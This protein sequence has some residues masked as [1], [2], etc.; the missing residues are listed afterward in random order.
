MNYYKSYLP[1]DVD[2]SAKISG[3]KNNDLIIQKKCKIKV[4]FLYSGAANYSRLYYY[5]YPTGTIPSVSYVNNFINN[6]TD[7]NIYDAKKRYQVFFIDGGQWSNDEWFGIQSDC[8]IPSLDSRYPVIYKGYQAL[9]NYVSRPMPFRNNLYFYGENGNGTADIEIPAGYSI[10]FALKTFYSYN[11]INVADKAPIVYTTTSL[12]GGSASPVANTQV[13]RFLSTTGDKAL[14]MG[15]EDIVK[16]MR[17]TSSGDVYE[18]SNFNNTDACFDADWDFND[19]IIA[20]A[21][22]PDDGIYTPDDNPIPTDPTKG[23]PIRGTLMFEDL[24]P[25]QGDYDMNDVMIKYV[26]TPYLQEYNDPDDGLKLKTYISKIEYEFF[27]YCD[28][29]SYTNDFHFGLQLPD[30]LTFSNSSSYLDT[31][32]YTVNVN[33]LG[34]AFSGTIYFTSDGTDQ[35]N[36]YL[37]T[38]DYYGYEKEIFDPHIYVQE[39]RFEVH[40]TGKTATS[41]ATSLTEAEG[42][43]TNSPKWIALASY[44]ALDEDSNSNPLHYPFAMDIPINDRV[45]GHTDEGQFYPATERTRIDDTSECG[46]NYLNWVLWA[47]NPNNTGTNP[48]EGWYENHRVT[49][50]E[51]SAYYYRTYPSYQA[52][53]KPSG[54]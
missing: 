32:I 8:S 7:G 36:P 48:D 37:L 40:L 1:E 25:E 44:Y 17:V 20:I 22:N 51:N 49:E 29:A 18:D 30:N 35:G 6:D 11:N 27:P 45:S 21:S 3:T 24:Y 16:D 14:I 9:I 15:F 52:Y 23:T 2:N 5:Y 47:S 12:N 4:A 28:G 10:G 31:P 42:Y 41:E 19:L 43:E 39:T 54:E 50:Y 34:K 26:I 33:Q 46:E 53:P 13:G 38:T